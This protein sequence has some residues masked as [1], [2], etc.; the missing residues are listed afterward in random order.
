[1]MG[2]SFPGIAP[3]T[4]TTTMRVSNVQLWRD[5]G[6]ITFTVEGSGSSGN[7]RLQTPF[8]GEPRPLFRDDRRLRFG[9]AEERT[10]LA[11]LRAWLAQASPADVEAC[12]RLDALAEWRNLPP[13][14]AAAI[15][16]HRMKSVMTCLQARAK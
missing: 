5:G 2:P 12:Q 16:L 9:G 1:M 10:L 13:D 15:P 6:T 11:D 4:G 14:L 8:R 3:A 7:Y